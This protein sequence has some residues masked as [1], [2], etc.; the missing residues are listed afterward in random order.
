MVAA[1][2][3]PA[4]RRP[5][6]LPRLVGWRSPLRGRGALIGAAAVLIVI[7]AVSIAAPLIT[8]VSPQELD[9]ISR[10]LPPAADHWFGT[11]G[12]GR[13]VFA[14]T[15]YGGRISLLVGFGV[16]VL[17]T[18]F[19]LLIG[20]IAGFARLADE[21]IMRVM[22]GLMAIPGILLAA[23]LMAVSHPGL[24]TVIVAISVPEVPRMVRLVR[25]MVLSVR[26]RPFVEAAVLSGTRLPRLLLRHVIPNILA[27]VV[28][29]ATFAFAMAILLESYLSLLGAGIP[30]GIPSWGNII[31]DSIN[32]VRTAFWPILFPGLF[33]A[34]TVLAVNIL[35]DSL[36]DFLDPRFVRQVRMAGSAP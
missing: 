19:G 16:A 21:L 35:G 1:I 32:T 12:L 31:T 15:L 27:P 22:D 20:A 26:E 28:V 23:A 36:R 34:I 25:S 2:E 17:T 4:H 11:D 29:Q 30:P 5:W 13:D 14:R 3:P 33:V 10:L 18:V 7:A 24:T 9:P 6:R 8:D